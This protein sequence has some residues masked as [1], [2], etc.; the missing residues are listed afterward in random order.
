MA[1]SVTQILSSGPLGSKI[2]IAVLG[3]GFAEADQAFYNQKV[4]EFLVDGVFGNDYFYEDKQ[5]FNIFRVNLISQDSGVS[6]RVYDEHGTPDDGSD[7]TIVSTTL[8]N[9]ALGYIF[10]GSWAHCWLEGG[11]NTGT[12]VNN[13]LTTWVPDY[14]LVV[15]ILNDPRY[16]GC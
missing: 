7:D 2:N 12:L 4:Q 16:G 3:D 10:S 5:A 14:Q 15:I 11:A 6:T 9:T 1:D 13:A 8:K